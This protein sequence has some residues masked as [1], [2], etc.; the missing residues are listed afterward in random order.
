MKPID[1]LHDLW[2]LMSLP[3]DR[4]IPALLLLAS[5]IT[6]CEL[7]R[8]CL[9]VVAPR[10]RFVHIM[11]VLLTAVIQPIALAI[12]LIKG[13]CEFPERAWI[14]V[15]YIALMYVIWY[16]AGQATLLVRRDSQG[17]DLGFMTVSALITFP[18]GVTGILL[19]I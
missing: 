2:S 5:F 10:S 3:P 8:I 12:V 1:F 15:G 11:E 4:L 14:N 17:A 9:L 19:C 6:L 18:V 7:T 16:V 13:A